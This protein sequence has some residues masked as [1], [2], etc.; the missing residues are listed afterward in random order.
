MVRKRI[1]SPRRGA[2]RIDLRFRNGRDL[3]LPR[4]VAEDVER[5]HGREDD[6]CCDQREEDVTEDS[7]EAAH[8]FVQYPV[9]VPRMLRSAKRCAADPGSMMRDGSRLCVAPLARCTASGT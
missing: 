3:Q 5:E 4:A 6:Q 9:C 8:F 1:A 7:K 2:L